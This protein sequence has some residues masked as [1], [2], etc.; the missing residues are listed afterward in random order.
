MNI[1]DDKRVADFLRIHK[2]EV[3]D[4]GFTQRV[5]RRLP[6]RPQR[7]SDLLT[8]LSVAACGGV[9]YVTDGLRVLLQAVDH[10]LMTQT[11]FAMENGSPQVWMAG[12][13]VVV[14]LGLRRLWT[15]CD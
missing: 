2:Q 8:L 14:G 13:A 4:R 10:L 5:M 7:V 1:D 11:Y 6:V 12:L 9:L 3:P 15:Q